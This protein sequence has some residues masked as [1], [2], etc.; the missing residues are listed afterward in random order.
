[1]DKL[2]NRTFIRRS[3]RFMEFFC[4]QF[5]CLSLTAG[6]ICASPGFILSDFPMPINSQRTVLFSD[7]V[8]N[9]GE[10]GLQPFEVDEERRKAQP[11]F[12]IDVGAS[13]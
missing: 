2:S 3:R 6:S 7:W 11:V 12:E 4:H 8:D 1:M 5:F 10:R 13:S 9:I